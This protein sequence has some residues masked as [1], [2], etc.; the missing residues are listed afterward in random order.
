LRKAIPDIH[1]RTTLIT[2]FPGEGKEEFEELAEFVE[3]QK[4]ER[5]GVFAY[6]GRKELPPQR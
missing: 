6:S 2:G 4:F 3:E 5:L 1:I